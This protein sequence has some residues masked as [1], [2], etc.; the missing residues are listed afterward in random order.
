MRRIRGP[1][2]QQNWYRAADSLAARF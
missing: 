2:P 1:D